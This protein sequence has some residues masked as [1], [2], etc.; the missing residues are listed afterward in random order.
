MSDSIYKFALK[1]SGLLYQT[2]TLLCTVPKAHI[3]F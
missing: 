3:L 1:D 2:K